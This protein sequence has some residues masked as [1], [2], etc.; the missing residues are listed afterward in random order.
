MIFWEIATLTNVIFYINIIQLTYFSDWLP[1][2]YDALRDFGVTNA[3]NAI[4]VQKT[5]PA[6]KM[7]L[8]LP[9]CAR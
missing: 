2:T 8:I 9:I 5:S 6:C 1:H 3:N 7:R 4:A